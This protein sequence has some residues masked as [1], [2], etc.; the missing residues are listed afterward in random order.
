MGNG[1][2]DVGWSSFGRRVPRGSRSG[3]IC[4]GLKAISMGSLQVVG[5]DILNIFDIDPSSELSSFLQHA[6][7]QRSCPGYSPTYFIHPWPSSY[8][9][10]RVGIKDLQRTSFWLIWPEAQP[11]S[12]LERLWTDATTKFHMQPKSISK[13]AANKLLFLVPFSTSPRYIRC[14]S[15]HPIVAL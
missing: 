7:S 3:W 8:L 9:G 5:H 1:C 13:F 6:H 11:W 15:W 2:Q 12:C 4:W 14:N 10:L